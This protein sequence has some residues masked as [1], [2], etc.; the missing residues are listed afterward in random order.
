M[1]NV[2]FT[3]LYTNLYKNLSCQM[4]CCCCSSLFVVTSSYVTV[5]YSRVAISLH[6]IIATLV[7]ML[8]PSHCDWLHEAEKVS[9]TVIVSQ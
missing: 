9:T 2:Q 3:C 6:L 4:L 1:H 8:L 7:S 5:H